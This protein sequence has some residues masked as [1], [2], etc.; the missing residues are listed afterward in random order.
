MSLL[1]RAFPYLT[2]KELK[3][4][5]AENP[6]QV[7]QARKLNEKRHEGALEEQSRSFAAI[8]KRTEQDLAKQNADQVEQLDTYVQ[9]TGDVVAGIDMFLYNNAEFRNELNYLLEQ[10]YKRKGGKVDYRP[11]SYERLAA[12][13][14][15]AEYKRYKRTMLTTDD[16]G[17]AN[18]IDTTIAQNILFRAQSLGKVMPLL[19]K[20]DLPYGNYEE[21]YYNKYGVAT[22]LAE[23]GTIADFNT[24][25]TDGTD[26]IKK[27]TWTPRDFALGLKQSFRSMKKLSPSIM[28]DIFAFLQ[29]ALTTGM[30]Y[31]AISGPG[32]GVTDSGMITVATSI[33]AAGNPYLTFVNAVSEVRSNRV[34]NVVAFMN[35]KAWGEFKKLRVTNEAYRD[36]IMVGENAA[37]DEVP[38]VVVDEA[39]SATTAGTPDTATVVLGDPSHYLVVTNGTLSQHRLDDPENLTRFTAFHILRDGAARFSDSFAKFTVNV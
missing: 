8:A 35:A 17:A 29:D 23:N 25:L 14:G 6:D 3:E 13:A 15:E 20:I 39:V 26:G 27:T 28:A 30:E 33:A 21:P 38:V 36:A 11:V 31:Q 22:Y 2:E 1:Q 7:E 18:T 19:A 12:R 16:P 34:Q 10:D 32:T 9:R 24:D 5:D 4:Y 37:I